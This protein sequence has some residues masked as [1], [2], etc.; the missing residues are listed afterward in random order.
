MQETFKKSKFKILSIF[1]VFAFILGICV[2]FVMSKN[3]TYANSS[4]FIEQNEYTLSFRGFPFTLVDDEDTGYL[5]SSIYLSFSGT[6]TVQITLPRVMT[7][8]GED[9]NYQTITLLKE[10]TTRYRNTSTHNVAFYSDKDYVVNYGNPNTETALVNYPISQIDFYFYGNEFSELMNCDR[11]YGYSYGNYPSVKRYYR[12]YSSSGVKYAELYLTCPNFVRTGDDSDHIEDID[13]V[14]I[15]RSEYVKTIVQTKEVYVN[16]VE[17]F[18]GVFN[19]VRNGV[20]AF[21]DFRIF[22]DFTLG[23]IFAIVLSLSCFVFIL[24]LLKK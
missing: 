20:E 5:A 3:N 23:H 2:P 21:L 10:T 17:T 16:G 24:H 22:N 18:S 12:F 4:T 8:A 6:S 19:S 1:C 14:R 13:I 7:T 15:D 11:V 9:F